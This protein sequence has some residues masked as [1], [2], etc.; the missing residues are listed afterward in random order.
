MCIRDRPYVKG[1]GWT[2]RLVKDL[3]TDPILIG[4]R[5][6]RVMLFKRIRSTGKFRRYLNPDHPETEEYKE[7]AHLADDE[8]ATMQQVIR[9]IA[10]NN[11][12]KKGPDHPLYR[13]P[14]RDALFP[15][16][17]ATCSI[18]GGLMYSYDTDQLKC[19]NAHGR[20]KDQCWNHVQ[21]NINV[22]RQKF[23]AWFIEFIQAEP[24]V[25]ELIVDFTATELENLNADSNLEL[26]CIR[27]Q[28]EQLE[29]EAK[30]IAK[31]IRK[32]GS[33]KAL[34]Q[35]ALEIEDQLSKFRDS[36][37]ALLEKE[38]QLPGSIS[39]TPIDDQVNDALLAISKNSFEFARLMRQ[40][41]PRFEI[42]PVQ[43]F[44]TGLVRPRLRFTVDVER[45]ADSGE[46]GSESTPVEGE[47]DLFTPPMHFRLMGLCLDIKNK[48]P[49]YS[50]KKIAKEVEARLALLDGD[51]KTISYMTVK[52]CFA[53]ARDMEAECLKEPYRILTEEPTNAS[54][55][56]S[57]N[58]TSE[59]GA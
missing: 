20:G 15:R 27:T 17:H 16:Q 3:L 35:E 50:L 37:T 47:L 10:E 45:L 38:E 1:E 9:E 59:N 58:T 21:V 18:C 42:V 11:P 8:F 56:K 29:R 19:Q 57:R 52:R 41:V 30:T 39:Q 55:W 43:A 26:S 33:F 32:G 23:I 25:R 53:T 7:I 31:A 24:G 40:I 46:Q 28:I 48:E 4:V 5:R 54:R 22:A 14:R 12:N 2:Q 13:R 49:K 44:D 34:V 51:D 36:E 6:F